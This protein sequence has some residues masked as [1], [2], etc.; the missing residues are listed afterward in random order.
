MM[1]PGGL[2]PHFADH[3][4]LGKAKPFWNTSLDLMNQSYGEAIYPVKENY[5]TVTGLFFCGDYFHTVLQMNRKKE[6]KKVPGQKLHF[7]DPQAQVLVVRDDPKAE[8][9]FSFAFKGG[10]NHELHNH[11]D[12][13]SFVV[14]VG[15]ALHLGDPGV[16]SYNV[17]RRVSASRSLIHPVPI[18]NGVEQGEG[19]AFKGTVL[20]VENDDR[21]NMVHLDIK[22]AYFPDADLK[23]LDRKVV[24]DRKKRE[25]TITDS[26]ELNKPGTYELPLPSFEKFK[27]VSPGVW[28]VGGLRIE[29]RGTGGELEFQLRKPQVKLRTQKSFV[30]LVC[31]FKEKVKSCTISLKITPLKESKK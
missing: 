10:H 11:N 27:E 22:A 17:D 13:G 15:N 26:C 24:Y 9:P 8:V 29:I 6:L 25:I 4:Q 3:G 21:H 18:P 30:M 2:Y 1:A 28:T 20:A 23:K 12:V 5:N 31:K 19:W 16:G 7:W 14:G